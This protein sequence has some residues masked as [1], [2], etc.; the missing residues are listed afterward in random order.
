M[1]RALPIMLDKRLVLLGC[2]LTVCVLGG[3]CTSAVGQSP[4]VA[5]E[6]Q[7]WPEAD[8]H[9]ELPS[10]FRV[11]AFVGLEQGT[12]FPFQQW[13]T[14]AGLGYQFKSIQRPH[15]KNID[16]DKEHY[17]VFGGGYE[18]LRTTQSGV[19]SDENRMTIDVTPGLRLP[20]QFLVRDR[21]WIELRWTDGTYLTTYRNMLTVERDF[22]VRGFRFSP[23]ASG[24]A[25]YNGGAQHSWDSSWYTAGVQWPYRSVFMLDT[26]YRRENCN[27]CIPARW[28]VGGATVNF[29]VGS[30]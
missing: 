19:V 13:Y 9:W 28:N 23:Y 18:Y 3:L 27:S 16:P 17:L 20:S 11:L 24:E 29:Y 15:M 4:R 25:F 26:F 7:V 14:A 8:V 21:N 5:T 1:P 2:L 30:R 22:L 6:T 12:S 10:N